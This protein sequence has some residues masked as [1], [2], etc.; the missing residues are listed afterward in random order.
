MQTQTN[1][2]LR[3]QL[4][5]ME[6]GYAP[7]LSVAPEQIRLLAY[8]AV[9]SGSRGLVFVSDTPLDAPD[10]DSRQRAM[11]LE[12][13]NLEM[14]LLEPWAAAGSYVA[15]AEASIPPLPQPP[16]PERPVDRSL[17]NTK[18]KAKQPAKKRAPETK[19]CEVSATLLQTDRVRLL[20]PLWLS[21]G[22]VRAVA[23]G[24]Q[25]CDAA[26]DQRARGLR[27]LRTDAPRRRTA[28]HRRVAGGLSITLDEFGLVTQILLAH[29]PS[30]VGEVRRRAR[31]NG[32][33]EAQLHRDL[34]LHKLNMV[35]GLGAAVGST[36]SRCTGGVVVR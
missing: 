21:A 1:E 36:N 31:Q 20:L 2:A 4:S 5:L 33:Q 16:A 6:P 8:I 30:I 11:T 29:D 26:G 22:A 32:Q 27:R 3:Q 15:T 35:I 23:V 10:P 14:Q 9:A 19:E 17:L 7:P 13:V 25:R 34:A 28:R 12:L 24:G 18:E